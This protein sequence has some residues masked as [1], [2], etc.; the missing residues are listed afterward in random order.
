MT[1]LRMIVADPRADLDAGTEVERCARNGA[2]WLSQRDGDS[3]DGE[4]MVGSEREAMIQNVAVRACAGEIEETVVGEI[5]H[6]GAIGP[7][8]HVKYKFHRRRETPGYVD[9]QCAGITL[10]SVGAGANEGNRG[11]LALLDRGDSPV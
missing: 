2:R 10:F 6:G 3:I 7:R 9:L 8:R 11:M 4:K 5:D 1:Q